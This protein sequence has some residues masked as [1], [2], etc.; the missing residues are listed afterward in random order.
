MRR[1]IP[2]AL[3]TL[4]FAST[5]GFAQTYYIAANGSDSNTSTQAQSKTTPWAHAPG[6]S[7]ATG[8]AAAYI[9]VPGD[10]FVF[11]GCDTWTLTGQIN[12][13]SSGSSGSPISYGVPDQ[14]WYNTSVCPSG[15]NRPIL[16]G[17]GTWPGGTSTAAFEANGK[18]YLNIEWFEFTNFY[19]SGATVTMIDLSS[20]TN[21]NVFGNYIHGWHA[22]TVNSSAVMY[23]IHRQI[24]NNGDQIQVYQNAIDGSDTDSNSQGTSVLIHTYI[25]GPLPGG[26]VYQNYM[27]S[28]NNCFVNGPQSFH[29]NTLF[30]CGLN[31][32]PGSGQHN[33]IFESNTDRPNMTFYNNFIIHGNTGLAANTTQNQ[34]AP[35][36]GTTSYAFNNVIVDSN[37]GADHN[38][39]CEAALSNPGGNCTWFNNTVEGGADTAG[40][41]GGSPPHNSVGRV[42]SGTATLINNHFI[43]SSAAP[44]YDQVSSGTLSPAPQNDV[45]QS[46]ATANSQ[47]YN[48]GQAY[49]F[50]PTSSNGA[51]VGAGAN[52]SSLCTTI[53]SVDSAAGTACLSDT[54]L[55]VAYNTF[56]H[57]VSFPART[58]IARPTNWDA[59]A[60]QFGASNAPN[61][62]TGLAATVQ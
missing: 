58:V 52:K 7:A 11:R 40:A 9:P 5:I 33:N 43:T 56:K 44:A 54:T 55:G 25:N 14:T 57:T 21:I 30:N 47:G 37:P 50:S 34:M 22:G 36:S 24:G 6:D 27:A 46:Q 48:L 38:M 13:K 32:A 45:I 2:L 19:Y 31:P 39:M 20:G 61:P 1:Q 18:S 28:S 59:G 17:G 60:Y 41:G 62:P 10:S 16:S 15:W 23:G 29:D 35:Q 3:V 53:A 49:P 42:S 4:I 12:L 26:A 8:N 51:T